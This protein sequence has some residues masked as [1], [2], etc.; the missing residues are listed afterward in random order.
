V[1]VRLLAC[2]LLALWPT[3]AW[4]E[5]HIKPFVG[6][7]FRE[8]TTLLTEQPA[9]KSHRTFGVSGSLLGEVFGVEGDLARVPGPLGTEGLVVVSSNVTTITVNAVV[10]LPRKWTRYTLRPY[11]VGGGGAMRVVA[12]YRLIAEPLDLQRTV[13]VMNFGGGATGF[14]NDRV[15]VS[16]EL[17]CFR[18][19]GTEEGISFGEEEFSFYRATMALVI[20]LDRRFR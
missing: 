16:W 18:S 3:T 10:G 1:R 4:A 6:F 20:G 11:L 2:A 9:D 19:F 8:D 14:F 5:W 17:R 13:R 7:T 12:D 15:G